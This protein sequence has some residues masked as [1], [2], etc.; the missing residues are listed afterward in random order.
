M[1]HFLVTTAQQYNVTN[2]T[3][4]SRST[5]ANGDCSLREAIGASNLNPGAV[6]IPAGTY[7]LTIPGAEEYLNATGSL[8]ALHGMGI[9]GAGMQQTIIDANQLDRAFLSR[10]ARR[11]GTTHR[12]F[13]IGDLTITN[14]S[15]TCQRHRTSK[16]VAASRWNP[17]PTTLVWNASH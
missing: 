6:L 16:T 4:T 14:G 3:D 12:S 10:P 7:K 13:A 8:D 9:Y 5:C 11:P 1:L 2:T 15:S 17:E